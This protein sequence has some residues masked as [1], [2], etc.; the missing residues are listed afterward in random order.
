MGACLAKPKHARQK[1]NVSVKSTAQ[2]DTAILQAP[3]V[4]KAAETS[5]VIATKSTEPPRN[6]SLVGKIL[7]GDIE[8]KSSKAGS[9]KSGKRGAAEQLKANSRLADTESSL[10]AMSSAELVEQ[11]SLDASVLMNSVTRLE[12]VLVKESPVQQT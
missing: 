6:R 4:A 2:N 8:S 9:F 7:R 11:Y 5:D 3:V 12:Q 1:E 10:K